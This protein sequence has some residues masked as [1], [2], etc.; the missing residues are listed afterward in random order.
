MPPKP[1][2]DYGAGGEYHERRR[3]LQTHAIRCLE[4][5]MLTLPPPK[6][7]LDVGCGEG[8]L[9]QWCRTAGIDALGM[10]LAVPVG[11][12]LGL[13]HYDLRVPIDLGVWFDWVLCWEVAEHLESDFEETLCNTLVRHLQKPGGRLL[14]TAAAPGQ[15]GPGH[16]NCRPAVYWRRKFELR[17]LRWQEDE[18][19]RLSQVWRSEVPQAPWYGKNLQIFAW[20]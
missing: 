11:A 4:L 3:H 15:R 20:A 2:V 5:A 1:A 6:T 7:V 8:A 9:V 16:V 10:D 14:F 13:L 18:S 12:D 17:G 19:W